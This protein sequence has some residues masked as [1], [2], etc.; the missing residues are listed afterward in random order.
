[1]GETVKT[2]TQFARG[3][4]LTRLL[5]QH[6]AWDAFGF[7]KCRGWF[8]KYL[9][10]SRVLFRRASRNNAE[11]F[12]WFGGKSARNARPGL[13]EMR[14]CGMYLDEW[15]RNLRQRITARLLKRAQKIRDGQGRFAKRAVM[16]EHIASQH[17]F[18]C[19]L[20]PL[21]DQYSDFT[22]QICG[23]VQTA[24]LEALQGR[25]RSGTQ[26]VDGGH[27]ARYRHGQ[28]PMRTGRVQAN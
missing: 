4:Q 11:L 2:D 9:L 5:V 21:I 23:V 27:D 12:G 8:A 19:V 16:F 25:P 24:E 6:K 15:F 18:R 17:G 14:W 10:H 26:I 13:T 20:E 1:M 3:Q 22:A 28:T 7:A